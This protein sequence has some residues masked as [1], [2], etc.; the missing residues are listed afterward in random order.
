MRERC[1]HNNFN[2]KI[3]NKNLSEKVSEKSEIMGFLVEL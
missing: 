1:E 3:S 2:A